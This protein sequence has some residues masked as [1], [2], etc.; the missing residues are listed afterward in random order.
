[1]QFARDSKH[2]AQNS[3]L[4]SPI[5]RNVLLLLFCQ[6]FL[7]TQIEVE[8]ILYP[9]TIKKSLKGWSTDIG[10]FHHLLFRD[11]PKLFRVCHNQ[12]EPCMRSKHTL[13]AIGRKV[14]IPV[15][16]IEVIGI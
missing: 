11:V 8:E 15:I 4:I 5:V 7:P 1:M 9:E 2:P 6:C 3:I 14:Q 10:L 12:M 16:G 13:L